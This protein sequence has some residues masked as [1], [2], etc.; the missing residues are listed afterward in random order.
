MQIKIITDPKDLAT[1]YDRKTLNSMQKKCIKNNE[2]GFQAHLI[3]RGGV[4]SVH[5]QLKLLDF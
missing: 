5:L 2:P 1:D 3:T 4:V